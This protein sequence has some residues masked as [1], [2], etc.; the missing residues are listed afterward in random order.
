MLCNKNN[1]F[2]VCP[3]MAHLSCIFAAKTES[4]KTKENQ[5]E[6]KKTKV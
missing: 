5:Y 4:N 1:S 3:K 2:K 6:Q